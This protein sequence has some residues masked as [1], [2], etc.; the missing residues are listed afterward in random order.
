M[1][2]PPGHSLRSEVPVPGDENSTY[3]SLVMSTCQHSSTH[4][5]IL[6]VIY[7]DLTLSCV[8]GRVGKYTLHVYAI[9]GHFTLLR[10]LIAAP[11]AGMNKLLK[12]LI[13]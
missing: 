13:L 5:F 2:Y 1:S 10:I 8:Q 7:I 3:D 12:Y 9:S 4:T 11:V 6:L